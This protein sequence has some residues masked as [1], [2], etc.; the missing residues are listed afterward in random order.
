M[1]TNTNGEKKST[2]PKAQYPH[3]IVVSV[4]SNR[5]IE[6][7]NTSLPIRSYISYEGK[8]L[9]ILQKNVFGVK[10]MLFHE[11]TNHHRSLLQTIVCTGILKVV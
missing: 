1:Q 2:T 11:A 10:I 6:L 8:N 9:V 3:R 7:E 4:K 5:R